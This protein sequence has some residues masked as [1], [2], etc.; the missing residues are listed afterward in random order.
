MGT[1]NQTGKVQTVIDLI[2]PTHTGPTMTH[3][4]LLINFSCMLNPAPDATAQK[5]SNEPLSMANLGWVMQNPYSSRDNLLVLDEQIA[6]KEAR[7]Y[8]ASGGGTIVD[9]TTI[10]I[11]RDPEGLARI[12]RGSG[13]N[14]VMGAGYYVGAT[15]PMSLSGSSED[16]IAS[17]IVRDITTGVG[18]S[19]VK[20]GIIGE[21]GCTWPLTTSERKVLKASAI[22]QKESGASILIHPGRNA[23]AP[24]EILSI[25]REGGADLTR[26]IMGHLDRTIDSLDDLKQIAAT[27]CVMEWD[28][29]GTE[30]SFYPLSDFDMPNDPQRLKYIR[31]MIDEDLGEN[32][33]ISQDIC[34]NHRLTHYGG[35]GYGYILE[36][37]VPRM[38][39]KGFSENEIYA[40]TQGNASRLLTII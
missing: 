1:Q 36:H 34:T 20:A 33:V 15:H 31:T 7:L 19:G 4:H 9:A 27:G 8:R 29:F 30:I 21:I 32:I 24:M 12:S 23:Q 25:L 37:I 10:G 18:N 5:L 26:V 38:R 40:L 3:E 22:A 13:I 11:G 14:I 35:H 17:D 16:E 6:M 2:E 28:L 39:T